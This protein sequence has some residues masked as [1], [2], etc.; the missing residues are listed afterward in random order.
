MTATSS[1]GLVWSRA[2]SA[3]CRNRAP[4]RIQ[5]TVSSSTTRSPGCGRSWGVALRAPGPR[6]ARCPSAKPRRWL[7][8]SS[9]LIPRSRC[10]S[11]HACDERSVLCLV[12]SSVGGLGGLVALGRLLLRLVLIH[13][14]GLAGLHARGLRSVLVL[15]P[16]GRGDRAHARAV[17]AVGTLRTRGARRQRDR[18]AM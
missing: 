18:I 6:D 17:H 9:P 14:R 1:A 8:L 3:F 5:T 11:M 12:F 7:V 13:A 15:L 2:P 10:L 4:S 16:L